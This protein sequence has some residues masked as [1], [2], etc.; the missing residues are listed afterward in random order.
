MTAA[1]PSWQEQ[2][3]R[4]FYIKSR[5]GKVYGH[6]HVNIIPNYNDTSVFDME[7]Y[8]N[9]AGSRNLEFDPSKQIIR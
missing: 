6:F 8:V 7:S 9:P 4:T 5:D 1:D 2:I 3:S